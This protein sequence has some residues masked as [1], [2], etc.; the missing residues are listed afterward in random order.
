MLAQGLAVSGGLY[1]IAGLEEVDTV[2]TDD[3]LG[4]ADRETLSQHVPD[5]RLEPVR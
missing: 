2:V 3:G 5:L 4:A 1:R